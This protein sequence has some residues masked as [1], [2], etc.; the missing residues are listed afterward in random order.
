MTNDN[1]DDCIYGAP[2]FAINVIFQQIRPF[3][4]GNLF[5][6]KPLSPA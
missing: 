6:K 5:L 2:I 4:N 3:V 1:T